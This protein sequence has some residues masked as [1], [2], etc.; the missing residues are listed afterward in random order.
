MTATKDLLQGFKE[1]EAACDDYR[2][3]AEYA[4]GE[5]PERFATDRIRYLIERSGKG[6]KFRFAKIPIEVLA[7]RVQVSAITGASEEINKRIERIRQAN[8]MEKQE[9]FLI[10]ELFTYGDAYLLVWPVE[11]EEMEQRD[12]ETVDVSADVELRESGVEITYQSPLSCRALYDGEDGRRIRF[13]I[14][15]WVEESPLGKVW[16]AELW[17]SDRIE[18]W[19]TDPG[20]KGMTEEEWRPYAEDMDGNEVPVTGKTWPLPHDWEEVPIKH[21]RTDLPYGRPEHIDAYGPQDAITKAIITQVT[22]G[23]ESYGWAER[24]RIM[25]DAQVL[26]TARDAVNWTDNADAPSVTGTDTTYTMDVSGTRRGPGTETKYHGTKEVGQFE[27]PDPGKLIDPVEQWVRF[28]ATVTATPLYEFD[29]RD[30]G[31]MSGIA[32]LR[33][34]APLR[35]KEKD[36]KRYLLGFLREVWALALKMNGV[37]DPGLIEVAWT[38]PEVISDPEWWAVAEVRIRQGV[39]VRQILI[40]ANYLPELIDDWLDEQGEEAT[41]DARIDRAQRLG[42]A[43]QSL[44]AA[45]ALGVA[46]E[47]QA[48]RLVARIMGEAS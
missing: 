45:V 15:R 25:D 30:S 16:H 46:D 14:R 33:A 38:P 1:L 10:R 20:S 7:N 41:L 5:V 40:E 22:V 19:V 42:D 2:R 17:Y 11:P 8:D 36:R 43:L 3:A 13:V 21:A 37:P 35:A 32:R 6:Y 18:P 44:G 23:I 34:D 29:P 27:P 26:D 31:Q 12:G 24:Y 9:P 47:A 4:R 28:M 39:P 48:Q